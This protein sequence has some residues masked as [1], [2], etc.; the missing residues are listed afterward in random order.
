MVIQMA[1]SRSR[2]YMADATGAGFA[3]SPMGLASALEKLGAYSG[4][5]PMNANP[6]HR[7]YVH[8]ESAEREKPDESVFNPPAPHRAHCPPSRLFIFHRPCSPTGK[9]R[10]HDGSGP[11]VLG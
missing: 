6:G 11:G 9:I 10:K 8:R 1:I 4:R 2:E 3:G 5:L 7:A